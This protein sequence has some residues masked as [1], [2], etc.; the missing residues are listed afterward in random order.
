MPVYV[1]SAWGYDQGITYH[2][3]SAEGHACLL[4]LTWF[5]LGSSLL[6]GKTSHIYL[7]HYLCP[8]PL[9]LLSHGLL[10]SAFKAGYW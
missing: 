10:P 3:M 8:S 2:F 6:R 4:T 9:P 7:G 5:L 1:S